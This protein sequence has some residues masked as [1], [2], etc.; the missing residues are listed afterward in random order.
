MTFVFTVISILII[1]RRSLVVL[2]NTHS[3]S[4]V[5]RSSKMVVWVISLM[6]EDRL[7]T[8]CRTSTVHV[9]LV[10][11]ICQRFKSTDTFITRCA[12]N[13]DRALSCSFGMTPNATC[14]SWACQSPC[15]T[16]LQT[17]RHRR[18]LD[19]RPTTKWHDLQTRQTT[20]NV[21]LNK[22]R[23]NYAFR[24][25]NYIL[26]YSSSACSCCSAW[27]LKTS[28]RHHN[29]RSKLDSIKPCN[30]IPVLASLCRY[31][32]INSCGKNEDMPWQQSFADAFQD[33]L[34]KLFINSV[35]YPPQNFTLCIF[36]HR[37]F[38]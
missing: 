2:F 33:R 27:V 9:I 10:S 29:C 3:F 36:L 23:L 17:W 32:S 37:N 22:L 18:S 21:S 28:T 8:G 26:I 11:R 24:L 14:S 31:W 7:V 38:N 34:L 16:L 25:S 4:V 12:V 13:W 19:Q 30:V 20:A 35:R 6:A 15:G 5:V 1:R